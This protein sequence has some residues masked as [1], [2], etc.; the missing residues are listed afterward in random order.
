MRANLYHKRCGDL[1]Q[2]IAA[3]PLHALDRHSL[4][5]SNSTTLST[6]NAVRC[7]YCDRP[8]APGQYYAYT[9]DQCP[10][11]HLH[12]ACSAVPFPSLTVAP[13][14]TIRFSCHCRPMELVS[15][16]PKGSDEP[17]WCFACRSPRSGPAYS[18]HGCDNFF[19]QSCV[20]SLPR[21]RISHHFHPQHPLEIEI[22]R[23]RPC[24]SCSREDSWLRFACSAKPCSFNLCSKCASV[25]DATTVTCQSH[26]HSLNLVT[27]PLSLRCNAC[28]KSYRDCSFSLCSEFVSATTV[29]CRSDDHVLDLAPLYL[30]LCC[31]RCQKSYKEKYDGVVLPKEVVRTESLLFRCMEMGCSFDVH[32]LCGPLPAQVE[33]EYHIH[34]LILVEA[35]TI[36]E[37]YSDEH[38]C[39]A[40][41]E[42]RDPEFRVYYCRD[43]KYVAHIHC[44]L[45]E[46]CIKAN[47]L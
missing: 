6:T 5:L 41:E 19:H 43:C 10:D 35:S 25:S 32:F 17:A 26:D 37:E 18:C 27:L 8:F 33:F 11:F 38:Y 4:T 30:S 15:D 22:S 20:E 34:P 29:D 3:H 23:P 2:Q 16:S 42:E 31:D 39:D 12:M 46:V 24:N 9:C 45:S 44:L 13:D 14:E 1:P 36:G 7:G 28:Q 21:R 40:C 47:F